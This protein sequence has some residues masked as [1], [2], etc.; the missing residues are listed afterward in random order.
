MDIENALALGMERAKV[1]MATINTAQDNRMSPMARGA[2]RANT[3]PPAMTA[4]L[5]GMRVPMALAGEGKGSP[6]GRRARARVE[7]RGE[8]KVVARE[9]FPKV[10]VRAQSRMMLHH[11]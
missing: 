8:M 9:S 2:T 10:Q 6:T 1:L 11:H 5:G 4:A 3:M 7:V